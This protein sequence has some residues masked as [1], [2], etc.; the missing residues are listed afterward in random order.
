MSITTRSARITAPIHY[1]ADT[2]CKK[3]IPIGPC[4][5]EGTDGRAVDIIWGKNGQNSV[6]LLVEE[7]EAARDHGQLVLLD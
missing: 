1:W 3:S 5:V 2:G 4:L 7:F 6:A